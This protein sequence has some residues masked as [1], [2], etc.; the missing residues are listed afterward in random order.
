V[1]DENFDK[2]GVTWAEEVYVE[3]SVY[4]DEAQVLPASVAKWA[5]IPVDPDAD[6][7]GDPVVHI[8]YADENGDTWEPILHPDVPVGEVSLITLND[9][10]F[11]T[12]AQIADAIELDA[13]VD[14]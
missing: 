12:F 2:E 6:W 13:R 1:V 10:R 9:S 3:V 14:R 4:A 5:G 7:D 8:P 11:F